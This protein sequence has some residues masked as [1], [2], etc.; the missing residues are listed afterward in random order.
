MNLRRGEFFGHEVTTGQVGDFGLSLTRYDAGTSIP[1]HTH[2]ET[3]VTFVM[4]GAYHERLSGTTRDCGIRAA[5]VHPAGERHADEFTRAAVCLNVQPDAGWL[6]TVA[7]RGAVIDAPVLL[8]SSGA[9]RIALRLGRELNH[10]DPFSPMVIEG[11]MLELF[12]ETARQ[13][14]ARRIPAW[15]C[16]VRQTV[17]SRFRERLSLASLAAAAGVHP[18]HLAR[19]FRRHYGCTIGEL[20]RELRVEYAMQRMSAG[21]TPGTVAADAGFADQSHLTRTFRALAGNTPAAFRRTARRA[22]R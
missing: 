5:V 18:T 20:Q 11:L 22:T 10:S 15:L 16:S 3:Y 13:P 19:A 12:A 21:D 1:W 4:H 6:Q 7:S 8:A 17:V 2:D 9:S 14:D